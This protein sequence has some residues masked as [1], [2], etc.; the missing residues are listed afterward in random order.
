MF[1]KKQKLVTVVTTL[2]LGCGLA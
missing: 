1:S 2:T